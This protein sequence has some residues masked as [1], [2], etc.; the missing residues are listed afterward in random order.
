MQGDQIVL[1]NE[2][3]NLT[4]RGYARFGIEHGEMK[5]H[6]EVVFV[7][8]DLWQ[9]HLAQAVVQIEGMEGVMLSQILC[10]HFRRLLDIDPGQLLPGD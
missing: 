10:L 8:V 6:K 7:F 4:G 3:R 2:Y 5:D 1:T 9:L